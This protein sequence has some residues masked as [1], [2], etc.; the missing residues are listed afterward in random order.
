MGEFDAALK[1]HYT[2]E[3]IYNMVYANNPLLALMPKYEQF[4]GR[5]LPVPIIFGNPQGRSATFSTAKKNKTPS[6]ITQFTLKRMKDYALASVDNETLEAS[7]GNPNAF[8][9]ALAT[10]VDGSIQSATRSLAI[11]MY[12]SGSGSIGK[13][14]VSGFSVGGT[15]LTLDDTENITNF[16]VGMTL[17]V[18]A[19]NGGTATSVKAGVMKIVGVNRNTGVITMG[20]TVDNADPLKGIAAI[21]DGDYIFVEGDYDLRLSGLE[22]W[23]PSGTVS[24]DPFFGVNR[25]AD[26][27]RL[28]GQSINGSM[29]PIEEAL[30]DGITRASREGGNVSHI[31]LSFSKWGDL[32]KALGSKVTYVDVGATANIGFRGIMLNGPKGPVRVI[33]DQNAPSNRAFGLQLDTWK[34]YSLG[35]AVKMLMSDGNRI[36]READSDSV[37]LRVGGYAQLGCRAPGFNFNLQLSS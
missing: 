32:E 26:V 3:R 28:A 5:N 14:K 9:E 30:I 37:E 11:A 29:L 36:L 25:T 34:C 6:K 7:R 10:E 12:G 18:S 24:S 4:G 2:D 8:M 20:E 16:E 35:P 27:T 31:F 15:T 21:A 13:I 1:E 17:A 22:A 19:T 33:P 23:L